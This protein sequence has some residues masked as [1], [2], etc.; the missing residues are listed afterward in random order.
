M[1]YKEITEKLEK[2]IRLETRPIGVKLYK[3]QEDLPRKPVDQKVNICQLVAMARYQDKSNAAVPDNM[4][5]SIG[6]ACIGLIETPYAIKSGKAAVGP[7]VKDLPA[8]KKFM[9]NT[10]KIGDAG[11]R[12]EGIYVEPLG[13]AKEGP[14]VVVIYGNPAQIM[15]LIH[16]TTY[17]NGE[18]VTADTVAEAAPCSCIGY[19]KAKYK[20][21]IG[22]PC[23]GDR[24]YGGTQD[25]D[26]VYVAPFA[27]VRDKLV[28]NLEKTAQGG[29]S[30]YPVP[31]Y[32]NYVPVM[33]ST[34][35][36]HSEDL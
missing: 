16:G 18:K 21:I 6:A 23:A 11:K 27:F 3:R 2:I 8:G 29:F 33:P 31:P 24:I 28:H 13:R 19:A 36:I 35:T 25:T 15:R 20:P 4:I 7:Y 17:D 22:F 34:Y 10:F 5:C 9:S 12:Y 14:D 26:L 1:S 32:M 30:V